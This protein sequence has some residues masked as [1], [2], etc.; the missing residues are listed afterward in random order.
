[1][2]IQNRATLEY[3]VS[4]DLKYL[5]EIT[6]LSLEVLRSV[7]SIAAEEIVRNKILTADQV[8]AWKRISTGC[9]NIDNILNGGIPVNGIIELYGCS[10]VGKT[11]LCLQ[12]ALQIQMNEQK[13]VVFISTEDV[14]PSKRLNQLAKAFNEKYSI[15]FNFEEHI[16]LEHI[17]DPIQLQNCLITQLPYFLAPRNIGLL[18]IDSI[19]GLFRSENEKCDYVTR[20]QEFKNISKTLNSLQD[21]YNLAVV[22]VNQIADNVAT[23]TSEAC[24]GLSWAN[25]VTCRFCLSKNIDSPM[26]KFEVIFA[27]DLAPRHTNIIISPDGVIDA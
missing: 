2:V 10:G 24:L 23:G 27:P 14:F 8:P 3:I 1:M 25:N 17:A 16:Y 21:Q 11:Q 4:C 7:K 20:S 22:V 9:Q 13:D 18:I 15:N 19:A 5:Q 12:L 26:R 6:N